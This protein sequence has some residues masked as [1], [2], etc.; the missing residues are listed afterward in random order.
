MPRKI[1]CETV[2]LMP[3]CMNSLFKIK[4]AG[5]RYKSTGI[6][7]FLFKVT[8]AVTKKN[9]TKKAHYYLKG[10]MHSSENPIT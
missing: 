1:L 10:A 8:L 6:N 4:P 3:V 7:K 9:S 5:E 2:V